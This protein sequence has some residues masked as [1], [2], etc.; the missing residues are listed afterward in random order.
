VDKFTPI[1]GTALPIEE[2]I[3]AEIEQLSRSEHELWLIC[4]RN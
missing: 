3:T 4:T 2:N 1:N